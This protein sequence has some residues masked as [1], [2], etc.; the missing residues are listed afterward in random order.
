MSVLQ[1]L[2][3]PDK[4][5]YLQAKPIREIDENIKQ[6]VRDMSET[7]YDSNGIG[8]AASQV[9]VQLRLFI[10]DLSRDDEPKNL[11]TFINPE[12]L[13][14]NG[15]VIGEE[16]CLSVPGIYETVLR[17]EKITVRYQDI[18]SQ[19][20]TMD[21]SGLMSVCIQHEKDHLDGKV[22]VDYL[23]PLKQNFIKKKM[24]KIYK[25]E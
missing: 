23:S 5:L 1:I 14:R 24:K 11:L 4:R 7:M 21:C 16:G 12:I 9:D 22:F 19:E 3:Y 10:M 25:P 18:N 2:H 17:A 13:S 20:H 15:E 8:L 6:L